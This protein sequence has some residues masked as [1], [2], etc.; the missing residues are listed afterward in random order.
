MAEGEGFEP[1][2]AR[3]SNG[4]RD[5]HNRP[6]CHPSVIW[7]AQ[8]YPILLSFEREW[9]LKYSGQALLDGGQGP[10]DIL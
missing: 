3:S 2:G 6:L 10:V 7:G 9:T 4:F 1:P 8:S 5:R